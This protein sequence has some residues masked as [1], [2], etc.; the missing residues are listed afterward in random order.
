[1]PYMVSMHS[2]I[3]TPEFER[4]AKQAALSEDEVAYMISWL[5]ENALAGDLIEGAGGARKVRFRRAGKGKSGGY[6]TIH[7]YAG[8]DVP[9]FLIT[10]IDKGERANLCKAEKNELSKVLPLLAEAYR[11]SVAKRVVKLRRS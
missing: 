8:A 3:S 9:V 4:K 10:L 11:Q 1:M 2:V 5:S 6:R 7:Y